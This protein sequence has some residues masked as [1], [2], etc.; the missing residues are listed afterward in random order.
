MVTFAGRWV[1]FSHP[2]HSPRVIQE[3]AAF[4]MRFLEKAQNL[5]ILRPIM[6]KNTATGH[7]GR[8]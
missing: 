5:S 3:D 4:V 1:E 2:I 8:R 6:P 7:A